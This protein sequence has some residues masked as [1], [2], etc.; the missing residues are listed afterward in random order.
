M[1]LDEFVRR[2]GLPGGLLFARIAGSHSYN[3][4]LPTSDT[5]F[6]GVYAA[7]TKSLVGLNLPPET[8]DG[9]KPDWVIHE[10]GKFA[11]L[12]LK[13]NPSIVEALWTDRQC[14]MSAPWRELRTCRRKFLSGRTVKQYLGY[15]Q[16][17]LQKLTKGSYLHTTGGKFNTKWAAHLIRLLMDAGQI[18]TGGEPA[19]WKEG[20]E[21]AFL[22]SIREG[23]YSDEAIQKMADQMIAKIDAV[24]PWNVPEEPDAQALE[25]WLLSVREQEW[26][27]SRLAVDALATEAQ[28]AGNY[29]P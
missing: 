15:A 6:F 28:Q 24:K 16:G 12:L 10:A 18:A 9:Q 27:G 29:G 4:A 2:P 17:Q 1:T 13:G 19:V 5:D 21:R 3:L 11:R 7:P 20:E 23:Q 25:Q 26:N 8:L 22:M 14:F